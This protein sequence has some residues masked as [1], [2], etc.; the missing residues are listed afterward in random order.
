M[1]PTNRRAFSQR[2]AQEQMQI[3]LAHMQ[4]NAGFKEFVRK[5]IN[6]LFDK[7]IDNLAEKVTAAARKARI[8]E[9]MAPFKAGYLARDEQ[10]RKGIPFGFE[11][12]A[13]FYKYTAGLIKWR[14]QHPEW[15]AGY[16]CREALGKEWS[17]SIE[18]MVVQQAITTRW[19]NISVYGILPDYKLTWLAIRKAFDLLNLF[20]LFRHTW[21]AIREHG[22]GVAMPILVSELLLHSLPFWGAK[23]VGSRAVAAA[24]SQIPVTEIVTPFYLKWVGGASGHGA[25][26]DFVGKFDAEMGKTAS[27]RRRTRLR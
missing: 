20:K 27:R 22:W 12:N 1:Y 9:Y 15:Q 10:I 5:Q 18:K 21:H 11:I 24:I 19:T 25:E 13:F 4:R 7:L 3:R 23:V 17:P 8:N 6:P 2:S 16:K 26:E 14:F